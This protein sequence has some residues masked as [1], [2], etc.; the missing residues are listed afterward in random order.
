[1]RYEV[2][3][4]RTPEEV[5]REALSFFG[6]G[7]LGLAL[8]REHPFGVTF[9]GGGGHVSIDMQEAEKATI[10]TLETREWDHQVQEFMRRISK[11]RW[12]S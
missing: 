2:Q 4:S 12:W 10:V 3:T 1:M 11:K 6:K 9:S 8:L 7:G 5:K